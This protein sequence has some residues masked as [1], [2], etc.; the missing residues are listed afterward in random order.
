MSTRAIVVFSLFLVASSTI[1]FLSPHLQDILPIPDAL[2]QQ[3][4]VSALG[5]G[6]S[7]WARGLCASVN[8]KHE[9]PSLSHSRTHSEER[10][11][12]GVASDVEQLKRTGWMQAAE[13]IIMPHIL[14]LHHIYLGLFRMLYRIFT[15]HFPSTNILTHFVFLLQCIKH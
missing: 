7:S 12:Q 1:P 8:W 3:P 10:S 6:S 4:C 2:L 13:K 9:S 11:S 5:G 14:L 15:I